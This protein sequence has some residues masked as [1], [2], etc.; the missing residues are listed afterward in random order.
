VNDDRTRPNLPHIQG[1]Q[2]DS[3][4]PESM[5]DFD[6]TPSVALG[7]RAPN[8]NDDWFPMAIWHVIKVIAP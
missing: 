3:S 6:E 5:P 7:T 4:L 8:L 1:L 2:T